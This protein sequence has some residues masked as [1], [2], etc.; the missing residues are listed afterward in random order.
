MV[1][2]LLN[3]NLHIHF[4]LSQA[5]LHDGRTFFC[6]CEPRRWRRRDGYDR[7]N[8]IKDRGLLC[9][10]FLSPRNDNQDLAVFIQALF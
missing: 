6:H 3:I 10:S 4:G 1:N 9:R 7:S 8:L 2:I 5:G